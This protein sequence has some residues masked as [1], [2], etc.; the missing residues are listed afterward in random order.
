MSA[1]AAVVLTDEQKAER[2][3]PYGE[4]TEVVHLSALRLF[5]DEAQR[6]ANGAVPAANVKAALHRA[7]DKR[8]VKPAAVIVTGD[9]AAD[10]SPAA[11]SL[12]KRLIREAFPAPTP[13]CYLPGRAPLT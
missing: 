2:W 1:A 10:K 5:A 7:A 9:V 11:Y 6:D 12:A 3:G 4:P 13:V 8:D